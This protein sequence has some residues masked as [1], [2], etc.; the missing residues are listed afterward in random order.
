M[1]KYTN[2]NLLFSH[3][4]FSLGSPTKGSLLELCTQSK[5]HFCPWVILF[6]L[7]RVGENERIS[8]L[9]H[10]FTKASMSSG[11]L[12]RYGIF[13]SAQ[14]VRT[15]VEGLG[16]S[17][18]SV[19]LVMMWGVGGGI[20]GIESPSQSLPAMERSQ[21]TLT[22]MDPSP[23]KEQQSPFCCPLRMHRERNFSAFL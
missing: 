10:C 17:S 11:S 14:V 12:L 16:F 20:P 19:T 2:W 22:V 5:S 23:G 9:Q 13:G 1:S 7:F 18:P 8:Q 3:W 21:E 15:P 6:S 4:L